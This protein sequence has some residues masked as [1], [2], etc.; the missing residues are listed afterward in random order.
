MKMKKS[1]LQVLLFQSGMSQNDLA[2]A[3][4][5]TPKTLSNKLTGQKDFHW[6]EVVAICQMLDIENP[7]DVFPK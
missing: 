2:K 1:A 3:L 7:L 4:C 5:I 6:K